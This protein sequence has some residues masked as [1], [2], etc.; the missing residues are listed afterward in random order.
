[1]V[2]AGLLGPLAIVVAHL[3]AA[4]P[5]GGALRWAAAPALMLYAFHNWDL[6]AVAAAVIGVWCWTRGRLGWAGVCFGV[7]GALKL[8][9]LLFVAPLALQQLAVGRRRAA[10]MALAAGSARGRRQPPLRRGELRRL[11]RHLPLSFGATAEHRQP[12]ERAR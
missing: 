11:V 6:L 3:L 4:W 12:L 7:G 8:Y 2:S 1:M 9:P 5:A 10:R